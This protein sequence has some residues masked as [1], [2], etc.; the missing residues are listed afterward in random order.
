[1]SSGLVEQPLHIR[2]RKR[3]VQTFEPAACAKFP[4]RPLHRR[5]REGRKTCRRAH[6]CD[7]EP[8]PDGPIDYSDLWWD[9][10]TPQLGTLDS[11]ARQWPVDG[12]LA[13]LRRERAADLVFAS[14]RKLARSD[15]LRG[16]RVRAFVEG[17]RQPR[18]MHD[19]E[20]SHCRRGLDQIPRGRSGDACSQGRSGGGR[21]RHRSY[22]LSAAVPLCAAYR[23]GK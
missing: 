20:P 11:P 13:R 21:G 19:G 23:C 12:Q 1:M 4:R 16:H 8:R 10:A 2:V 14:T 18:R 9:P 6:A 17:I 3:G 22:A 7:T 5:Q 15:D